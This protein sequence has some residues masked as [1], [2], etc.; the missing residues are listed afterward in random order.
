MDQIAIQDRIFPMMTCFGCGPANE[1]GLRLKSYVGDGCVTATFMPW[2]EHDNGIGFL[3]GGI[4]AT[5][6]DCHSAAGVMNE[7]S[8]QGWGPLPGAELAYLT[9]GID[10]R[11]LRPS[12][13]DSPV[14]LRAV[15]VE[16]TEP[17]IV[18]EA[19]LLFDGK[20]RATGRAVWKRWRPR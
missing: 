6:L 14:E 4:I 1:R 2:P 12:P 7:A 11:Y 15:I 13:L 18:C 8:I 3:N 19:Q 10:V 16:A 17:E 20:T 5:L 9:A